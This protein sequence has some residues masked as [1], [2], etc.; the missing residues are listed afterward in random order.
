[1]IPQL[2]GTQFS[3]LPC[4]LDV[5]GHQGK[6]EEIKLCMTTG[7]SQKLVP[8]C[9]PGRQRLVITGRTVQGGVSG[10][11]VAGVELYKGAV[12]P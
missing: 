7:H 6:D 2:V 4:F 5:L 9:V 1:M 11:R 10:C 8:G 12:L 3:S